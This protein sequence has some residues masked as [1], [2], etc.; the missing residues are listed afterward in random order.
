MRSIQHFGPRDAQ[1]LQAVE[2]RLDHAALSLP[3]DADL[4]GALADA[5]A[6][7]GA[8]SAVCTL[9][10]GSFSQLG[11][12]MPALSRDAEHAVY[13]S[14]RH[15]PAVPVTLESGTVTVG[16]RAGR[17]WFHCHGVWRDAEGRRLAGHVLPDQARIAEPIA[18]SAWLLRGAD[19]VVGRDAETRFDLFQPVAQGPASGHGATAFALQVRP[20]EDIGLA[21]EAQCA[22]RGITHARV[23]G[24]VG[25]LVGAAFDDGRTVEPFVTEVLIHDGR[26]APGADGSPRADLDVSVVDHTGG[27]ARGRL[28]RGANPVLVTFELVVEPTASD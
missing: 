1:R 4:L 8:R 10:G 11:F 25:S 6:A 14:E 5:V 3:G 26:L 21:L 7:H 20:N 22:M 19:Y 12:V 18:A 13:Y 15:L 28:R 27:L 17:P 9:H 24:G 23:R 16:L 2:C